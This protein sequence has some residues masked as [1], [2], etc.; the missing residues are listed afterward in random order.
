MFNWQVKQK[1][2]KQKTKLETLPIKL[3]KKDQS[4][5]GKHVL[6]VEL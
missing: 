2:K 4:D 6:D 5:H 1:Q 3:L